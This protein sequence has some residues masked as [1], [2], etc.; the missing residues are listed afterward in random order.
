MKLDVLKFY[1]VLL[2][3]R[4]GLFNEVI[5]S[6]CTSRFAGHNQRLED[7]QLEDQQFTETHLNL[8]GRLLKGSGLAK[9]RVRK[10]VG[11]RTD[12]LFEPKKILLTL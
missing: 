2:I 10:L 9:H 5:K 6:G 4:L 1:L 8:T 7:H 11:R 12:C 3:L